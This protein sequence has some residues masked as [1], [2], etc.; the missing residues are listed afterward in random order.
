MLAQAASAQS[1]EKTVI[2]GFNT[3]LAAKIAAFKANH[4]G[5]STMFRFRFGATLKDSRQVETYTWDS[6]ATFTRILNSPTTYGFKDATT[7]GDGTGIFWGWVSNA[8]ALFLID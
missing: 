1:A 2:Q 7:F 5:V 3:K 6:S 4:T 8:A